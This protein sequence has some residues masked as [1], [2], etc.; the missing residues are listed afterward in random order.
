MITI[1][2]TP[3]PFVGPIKIIQDNAIESW[4][5]LIPECEVILL[6]KDSGTA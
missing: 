4:K 3:K 6:G 2:A 5:R 1:F